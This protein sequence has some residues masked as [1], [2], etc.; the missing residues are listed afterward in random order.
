MRER[1]NLHHILRTWPRFKTQADTLSLRLIVRILQGI[2]VMATIRCKIISVA[3]A[4]A[5]RFKWNQ[6]FEA[7]RYNVNG[8]F[9]TL[10]VVDSINTPRSTFAKS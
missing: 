8:M 3:M 1:S 4:L 2:S 9:R 6:V 10:F 5:D 7:Q